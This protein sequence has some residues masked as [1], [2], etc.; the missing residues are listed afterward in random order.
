MVVNGR[1]SFDGKALTELGSY[2]GFLVDCPFY[3]GK[4][5]SF[6]FSHK[7]FKRCFNKGYAWEVLEIF[8][9]SV[10]FVYRSNSKPVSWLYFNRC[11][12]HPYG[13]QTNVI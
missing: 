9:G 1:S 3:N 8:S 12:D 6:D 4:D 11:M 7:L 13:I 10:Q 2:N 5:L